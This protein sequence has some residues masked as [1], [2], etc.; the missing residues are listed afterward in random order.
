M[1]VFC[2]I[3]LCFWVKSPD[4]SKEQ[5]F[6]LQLAAVQSQRLDSAEE[7]TAVFLTVRNYLPDETELTLRR[8]QHSAT[9]L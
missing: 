8:L 6:Y 7:G 5:S 3:E 4:V 9:P 1:K 2:A